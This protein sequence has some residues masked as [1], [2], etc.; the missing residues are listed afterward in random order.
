MIALLEGVEG[1]EDPLSKL[2]LEID[3]LDQRG[4][5]L[6]AQGLDLRRGRRRL[7]KGGV[8][9]CGLVRGGAMGDGVETLAAGVGDGVETL[10]AG[11]RDGVETLAA[12]EC[13]GVTTL[14]AG[15]CDDVVTGDA[16]AARRLTDESRAAAGMDA[17]R[18][19]TGGLPSNA[20]RPI[21]SSLA[22]DACTA[23]SG[24]P[25]D[26]ARSCSSSAPS[27]RDRTKPSVGDSG[28]LFASFPVVTGRGVRF[29]ASDKNSSS[30]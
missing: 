7:A 10:A 24:R 16:V 27:I 30:R 23:A 11:E 20:M 26:S 1:F 6:G 2:D 21:V 12:G 4:P 19:G 9:G 29:G 15:E 5:I 8:V 3:V 13:D 14:A 17:L 18:G 25:V 28:K 22:S